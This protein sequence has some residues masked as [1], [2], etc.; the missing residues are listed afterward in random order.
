MMTRPNCNRRNRSISLALVG[1]LLLGVAAPLR[2][3]ND[4]DGA[5]PLSENLAQL[6][7]VGVSTRAIT[8]ETLRQ[9]I[10]LLKAALRLNPDEPRFAR[11]L[12][13]AAL[14]AGD[15]D[16]AI[17]AYKT[18]ARLDPNDRVAY[19]R[20]IDLHCGK[21]QTADARLKYL[22]GDGETKGLYNADSISAE[23]RA[24]AA[25]LAAGI[26]FERAQTSEAMRLLEESLRLF[27]L[28]PEALKL[29]WE[30]TGASGTPRERVALL[31]TMLR[32]NPAQPGVMVR[33][34]AELA[35]VGMLDAATQW[36]GAGINLAQRVG[37]GIG[38]E[39]FD[40]YAA[41]LVINNQSAGAEQFSRQLLKA[42]PRDVDA[43]F[44]ALLAA[45]R[46]G[47]ADKL[48]QAR[49]DAETALLGRAQL[50]HQQLEGGDPAA[51]QPS[52]E[53]NVAADIKK[54][55]EIGDPQ[56]TAAYASTLADLAWLYVY[57]NEQPAG[58]EKVLASLRQLLPADSITLTRL[59]GWIYLGSGR[60][61][62]AR[63]KLSAV[64]DR[65]PLAQLGMILLM[66]N[67]PPSKDRAVTEARQL[68]S[69]NSSGVLGAIIHDALRDK[70]P[71]LAAGEQP[72][73]SP[74]ALDVKAEL[75]A[76]PKEWL[77]FIDRPH[78]FYILRGDP[79]KVSHAYGEPIIARVTVQNIG[80]YDI[81]I[82][83]E[84]A[85]RPDVW[86]DVVLRGIQQGGYLGVAFDRLTRHVVLKPRQSIVQ[87]VRVD[88]GQLPA[89][90]QQS[91]AVAIPLF[92][93]LFDN[94][95]TLPTG[96]APGP[97]GQRQQFMRPVNRS[98]VPFNEQ[99]IV[100]AINE[101]QNGLP[102]A[103]LRAI[104]LLFWFGMKLSQQQDPA[105]K[106]RAGEI[107]ALLRRTGNDPN[108]R[109]RAW[110]NYLLARVVE[111]DSRRKIVE[112]MLEDSAWESRLLAGWIIAG[113]PDVA[114][115][116]RVAGPLAQNDPDPLVKE[117]CAALVAFA[118]NPAATQPADQPPESGEPSG[119][120]AQAR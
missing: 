37:R 49:E 4:I 93:S 47:D 111:P 38:N 28:Y 30:L 78:D 62:E 83:P 114:E 61:Q 39:D 23:V 89:A 82:G 31:L 117:F 98:G 71:K 65:D 116:K 33:I 96:I 16:A 17:E 41:L 52:G 18:I 77:N 73:L 79:L 76:F 15:T 85:I 69:E 99:S 3:A 25:L 44:A 91:A 27:P 46:S 107:L 109:V 80:K 1:A 40:A 43:A 59:E 10:A 104:E 26:Y 120:A 84:G 13:E 24:H 56:L 7:Q 94:P 100:L 118:D 81:T 54:L 5:K 113:T 119:G 8:S 70:K 90:L 57:F 110:T 6:A 115:W 97:G 32:S 2:A 106:N 101:V 50:I 29:K 60:P 102:E 22:V 20:L 34:G 14:Q 74:E 108:P 112:A 48:T 75:E 66:D 53:V 72:P 88:Q 19:I 105:L 103:K 42:D 55:Q 86:F 64:A 45:R 58:A 92:F 12:A 63:V 9:S 36:Y 11:L 95:L 67:D 87:D 35:D 51:T 68:M 21:M